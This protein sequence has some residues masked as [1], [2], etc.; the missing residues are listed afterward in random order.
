LERRLVRNPGAECYRQQ[1][2]VAETV[3]LVEW[4]L[5]METKMVSA[6]H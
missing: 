5:R 1:Q 2:H 4:N 6:S 3:F